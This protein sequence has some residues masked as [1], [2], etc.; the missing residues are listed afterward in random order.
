MTSSGTSCLHAVTEHAQ[1]SWH[2]AR[3]HA[4]PARHADGIGDIRSLESNAVTRQAVHR[5]RLQKCVTGT[6]DHAGVLLVR[7]DEQ[8]VG[9][10]QQRLCVGRTRQEC[11]RYG[12]HDQQETVDTPNLGRGHRNGTSLMQTEDTGRSHAEL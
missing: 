12:R 5:R 10:L 11:R 6:A 2:H 3:R 8:D 7:H 4:D 9:T 1:S